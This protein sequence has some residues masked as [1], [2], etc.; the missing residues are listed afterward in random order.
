M[1]LLNFSLKESCVAA[2]TRVCCVDI[3]PS[4]ACR[5]SQCANVTVIQVCNRPEGDPFPGPRVPDPAPQPPDAGSFVNIVHTDMDAVQGR[6]DYGHLS[7]TTTVSLT[8]EASADSVYE[9]LCMASTSDPATN[10]AP[11]NPAPTNPAASN[12]APTNPAAS[13]SVTSRVG[14][15]RP[16][17]SSLPNMEPAYEYLYP[18]S[19]HEQPNSARADASVDAATLSPVARAVRPNVERSQSQNACDA[20]PRVRGSPLRRTNGSPKREPKVG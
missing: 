18:N 2:A 10:P 5:S 15:G 20:S 19:S 16:R 3:N 4:P 7:L 17:K 11:S 12:P 1:L 14:G 13:A 6:S 9:R 8:G